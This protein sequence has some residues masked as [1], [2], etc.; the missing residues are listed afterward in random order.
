MN[1]IP[2][3]ITVPIILMLTSCRE[4]DVY[5]CWDLSEY[6][7]GC[8]KTISDNPIVVD[9]FN[10]PYVDVDGN[11]I[12]RSQLKKQSLI[13]PLDSWKEIKTYI[14]DQCRK[15]GCQ[16]IETKINEM[17]MQW[18]ITALQKEKKN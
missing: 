9:D 18:N 7:V 10:N 11:K 3:L 14:L 8:N 4:P 5:V 2:L 12:S 1:I 17:E 6:K 15:H 13:L 16:D